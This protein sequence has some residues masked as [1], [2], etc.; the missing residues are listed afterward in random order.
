MLNSKTREHPTA[1]QSMEIMARCNSGYRATAWDDT[2]LKDEA[3]GANPGKSWVNSRYS[4]R[5]TGAVSS[6]SLA[7]ISVAIWRP[8]KRPFSMKI[9]FVREPATMT[10]A[11]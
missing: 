10:P 5:I 8:W 7:A 9:S 3:H 1:G 4:S 2:I 6:C 11:R